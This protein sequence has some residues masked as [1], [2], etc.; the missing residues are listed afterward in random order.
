RRLHGKD[1]SYD[2][3]DYGGDRY[4]RQVD[5][6]DDF[7]RCRRCALDRLH[8]SRWHIA[9]A[10]RSAPTRTRSANG[11]RREPGPARAPAISGKRDPGGAR[12]VVRADLRTIRARSF[13][14]LF[15]KRFAKDRQFRG[16]LES[17]FVRGRND[18]TRNVRLRPRAGLAT[19]TLRSSRRPGFE[20]SRLCRRQRAIAVATGASR[21][22]DRARARAPGQCGT[23][24]S[25]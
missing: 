9:V 4:Q 16:R 2:G 18:S 20:W 3:S 6:A 24:I 7:L 1:W 23:V 21:E 15:A 19:F 5:I 12:R 17:V 25:Q 14:S 13:A 11:T 8:K 10:R 22:S